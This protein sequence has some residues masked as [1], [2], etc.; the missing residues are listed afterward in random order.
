MLVA[1]PTT[2]SW[3]WITSRT[4]VE[5]CNDVVFLREAPPALA[6]A[7]SMAPTEGSTVP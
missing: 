6:R 4:L 1:P 7:E 5:P 3:M 2:V